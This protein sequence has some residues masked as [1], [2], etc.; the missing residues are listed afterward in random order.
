MA[1]KQAE[2]EGKTQEPWSFMSDAALGP[3]KIN[4]MQGLP[5]A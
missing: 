1:T 2:E 5:Q 4:M 3:Y